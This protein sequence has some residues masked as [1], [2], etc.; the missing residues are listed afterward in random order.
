MG[1]NRNHEGIALQNFHV[2][3]I[4]LDSDLR[5]RMLGQ[6]LESAGHTVSP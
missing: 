1:K 6:T 4:Y 5:P 3:T 2:L